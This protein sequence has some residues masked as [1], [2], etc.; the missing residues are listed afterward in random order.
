MDLDSIKTA[1]V[2][3][4]KGRVHDLIAANPQAAAFLEERGKDLAKLV[5]RLSQVG[6]E[7][8]EEDIKLEIRVSRQA[9]ENEVAGLALDAESAFK[10]K[11]VLGTVFEFA[12]KALPVIMALL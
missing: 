2:D 11:E 3:T 5:L 6:D 8:E 1:L 9:A 7:Q 4:V 12:E 10:L